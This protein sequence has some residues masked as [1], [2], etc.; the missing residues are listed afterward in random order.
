MRYK[1]IDVLKGL[2]V[3]GMVFAHCLQF[4]IL[5]SRYDFTAW[6]I[7]EFIGLVTFS[8][9][10]FSFGFVCWHAYIKK[11]FKDAAKSLTVNIFKILAAFYISSFAFRIFIESMPL[12]QHRI[13]EMLFIRRLAGW[14]E[15][16]LSFA[17]VLLLVLAFHT[18]MKKA[19]NKLPYVIGAIALVACLI[20]FRVSEPLVALFVGQAD[21][22]V[23]AVLPYSLYFAG[24]ILFAQKDLRFNIKCL[25]ISLAGGAYF[26]IIYIVSGGMP[27]RFPLSLAYLVGGMP[28]VYLYYLLARWL[29]KFKLSSVLQTIG[30]NALFYLLLHNIFIF[31][32]RGVPFFRSTM[33][34][35]VIIFIIIMCMIYYL[36]KLITPKKPQVTEKEGL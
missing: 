36:Q 8:G 13:M 20:P 6:A 16:I 30:A 10:M 9:F 35:T 12:N 14:S 7:S 3:V 2:L 29:A 26:V 23:F 22:P 25:L 15:F 19:G 31:T 5:R 28:L 17:G 4:F 34:F 11:P 1:E 33:Q 21:F 27:S 32:I 18:L 24:G